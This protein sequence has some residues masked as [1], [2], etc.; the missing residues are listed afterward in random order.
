VTLGDPLAPLAALPGVAEAVD[1]T[2]AAMDGLLREPALRRRRGE[3][4]AAARLHAAWASAT[5]SGGDVPLD[6][7]QPP[8]ADDTSG[9]LANA[10]LNVGSEVGALAD[11]WRNA[12][13]QAIARLHSVAAT[14]TSSSEDLGRPR[15][16]PG[17]SER[18]ATLA[19]VVS[20]TEVAGVIVSAVVHAELMTVRP[21]GSFDDIVARAA[22]RVVLVQ[23]GVDPDAI[24][25]PEMGLVELGDGAYRQALQGYETGRPTALGHWVTFHAAAVQRG[26]TFARSL[27]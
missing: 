9:Q 25:V 4:R 6:Q 18:L 27:C 16:A 24:A 5:L 11:T 3:V 15:R 8:F 20:Q 14:G 13:L 19:E 26:A 10:A 23:T 7:F 1:A 17:V 21:F 12:P 22:A 2:R